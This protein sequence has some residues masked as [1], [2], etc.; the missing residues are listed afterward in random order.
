[1]STALTFHL[2]TETVAASVALL[3]CRTAI[4]M[5][6]R[7]YS[8]ARLAGLGWLLGA[9]SAL[10][11]GLWVADLA[12]ACGSAAH[13]GQ[14]IDVEGLCLA[15]V[16]SC[17][18]VFV[19]LAALRRAPRWL[20]GGLLGLCLFVPCVL[21]SPR[22]F[23]LLA[24]SDW[25]LV[26]ASLAV[27]LVF[28]TFGLR[29]ADGTSEGIRSASALLLACGACLAALLQPVLG[30]GLRTSS[31]V[32]G[33]TR[34]TILMESLA[35]T[36][37]LLAV[38]T[39]A[40]E[41]AR[42]LSLEADARRADGALAASRYRAAPAC[43]L[44][45]DTAWNIVDASDAWLRM[46]GLER[47]EAVGRALWDF[48]TP[49][50]AQPGRAARDAVMAHGRVEAAEL[51]F[52][53]PDGTVVNCLFSGCRDA[54]DE[55]C[56]PLVHASVQD[57][58]AERRARRIAMDAEEEL[59][60]SRKLG[61][62]GQLTGG[63]AHDFN[64]LLTV[65]SGNVDRSRDAISRG[66]LQRADRLLADARSSAD[67]ATALAKR[68]LA[69]C[70]G[71]PGELV[72]CDIGSRMKD[73]SGLVGRTLG[74]MVSVT[75]ELPPDPTW[76]RIDP[77][78]FESAVLNMALN[79]RDAMP[80]GGV[81]RL[82]VSRLATANGPMVQVTV[83]DD[84]VGMAPDVLSRATEPFFT[85]KEH[86][87][88]T[89]LGLPMVLAFAARCG[90]MTEIE[91]EPGQGTTIRLLLPE[92]APNTAP[93]SPDVEM[94]PYPV[95]APRGGASILVVEDAPDVRAFIAGTLEDL[96]YEVAEAPDAA[97]ALATLRSGARI[98][99][100]LTDIGLPGLDGTSLAREACLLRPGIGILLSTGDEMYEGDGVAHLLRK[101]YGVHEMADKV[102]AIIAQAPSNVMAT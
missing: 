68:L 23:P 87:R 83:S 65:V 81:L 38:A 76:V 66:D 53:R 8:G 41:F 3:A 2:A 34:A 37:I 31:A 17:L 92:T 6:S 70:R 55:G 75:T 25:R 98:D 30:T 94:R 46:A 56:P 19:M 43:L 10:G 26:A 79:S 96:G 50:T 77:Y 57:V 24:G 48:L 85:T 20:A 93:S 51:D 89:G 12:I 90:G 100:V 22:P 64:N 16:A 5:L 40:A 62:I 88:G 29:R 13:R 21:A 91:S 72:P 99:L 80:A 71:T 11:G 82:S 61:A 7:F 86:G 14:S 36:A 69:F 95:S 49:E 73:V 18:S 1:V 9:A 4:E 32:L 63:I 74:S 35:W 67:S 28:A 102:R 54:L 47:P 27:S 33:A 39:V 42:R 59:V 44:T 15:L 45:L 58:S 101:P 97:S 84:G 60:V 78:E 52:V